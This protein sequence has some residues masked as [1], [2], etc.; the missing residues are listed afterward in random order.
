M[1]LGAMDPRSS[2]ARCPWLAGIGAYVAA[3][4]RSQDRPSSRSERYRTARFGWRSAVRWGVATGPEL[5]QAFGDAWS[6]QAAVGD[7]IVEQLSALCAAV[8]EAL[9]ELAEA[10]DER[11][12]VA[13]LASRAPDRDVAGYLARCH[14]VELALAQAAS[15]GH[16]GAIARLER[17]HRGVIDATCW[18]YANVGHS[19]ADLR[20]ILREKL[21]V[22]PAG[23]RP[24]LAEYAGQGQLASWL[25]ITA[26]RVFLD[27][28][29]RKDRAREAPTDDG[30]LAMP[31][32]GDLSLEVIKAEYRAAVGQAMRDAAAG[33]DLA[34]RHLLHQHFVAGL[35]IDQ[36]GVALGI[37]R[38]TAARRLVRAREALVA[39]T[40][41]LLV[42]R[43]GI[44]NE[45]L[46]EVIGMVLSRL[47]VSIPQLFRAR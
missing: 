7:E 36:L 8:N 14:P 33:L 37:H 22:A 41:A 11:E 18:R 20:Q 26:V 25:R 39:E 10:I 19:A 17:D 6:C 13:M 12:L 5:A 16:A 31:D 30:V 34:D 43:L 27:L 45:E 47:D 15:R 32:P 42:S 28:G 40:R 24:K 2:N 21:Y 44:S 4:R 1:W 29:R 9:P 38:A 23:E 46:D 3:Q 35:S